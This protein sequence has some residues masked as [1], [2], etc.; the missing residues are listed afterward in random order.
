MIAGGPG[1][2]FSGD[3]GPATQARFDRIEG[4]A[5]DPNGAIYLADANNRRVRRIEGPSPFAFSPRALLY[6]FALG[7]PPARQTLTISSFDGDARAFRLEANVPWLAF[8]PANGN[9]TGPLAIGVT[10]NPAGLASGTY[11][12]QI[13]IVDTRTGEFTVVPVT[14]TISRTAQQLRLSQVG[15]TFAARAGGAAPPAQSFQV[16]NSGVGSMDWAATVSTIDGGPWLSAAPANGTSVAGGA[17]PSVNVTINPANLAAGVYHGLV[18]LTAPSAD[19]SPQSAVVLLNVLPA[20][21]QPGPVAD[22]SGL[23]F[24]GAPGGA[25]PAIQRIQLSNI[26]GRAINYNTAVDLRGEPSWFT[27]APATGAIQPG[28]GAAV[29]IR[30]ALGNIAAG[31]Y[32]AELSITFTPD[33]ITIRVALLLVV[34]AGATATAS[35]EASADCAA[36]RLLPVFRSP[37]GGYSATAGWPTP[38]EVQVVDDCGQPLT[39]GAVVTEFSN[40]DTALVFAGTGAGRWSATWAARGVDAGVRVKAIA[41]NNAGVRGESEI[42]VGVRD[43]ADQPAVSR[44]GVVSAASFRTLEPLAPGSY[45]SISGSRFNAEVRLADSLPLPLQLGDTIA[46]LGGRTLPLN[47]TSNGQVNAILPYNVADN[48]TVQLIVRRGRAYS[49]PEPVLTATAQ[50]AVFTFDGTGGGQGHIYVFTPSGYVLADAVR[51]ARSGDILLLYVTGMGPVD[52]PVRAGDPAPSDPLARVAGQV[53]VTIKGR[54]AR[55]LF[56]GLAPGFAGVYQVNVEVP[57]GV[58]ADPSAPLVVEVNGQASAPVTL[59]TGERVLE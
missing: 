13:R 15:L 37:N 55:L 29:E 51:P 57:A 50:P 22:P 19:N 40:G 2:G 18:T 47:L 10:A 34:S 31:A 45:I 48:T 58:E 20:N 24:T 6:A 11:A 33:N 14:V 36:T 53:R 21:Q 4:V 1:T 35:K 26:S 44:G 43:S 39:S 16:I 49:L 42:T 28:Q 46:V 7:A 8:A 17:S 38:V 5:V 32:P 52:V 56:A 3:G 27:R 41:Q 12:A 59:A 25:N 23:V 54:E 9:V 30:P